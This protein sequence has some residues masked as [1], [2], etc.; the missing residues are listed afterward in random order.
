LL[1]LAFVAVV[2][3]QNQLE[4]ISGKI[5]VEINLCLIAIVAL[6]TFEV[7][8]RTFIYFQF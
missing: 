5:L 2:E 7:T 3:F 1:I 8:T 4:P 6:G